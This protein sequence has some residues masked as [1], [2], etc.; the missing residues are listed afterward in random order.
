M[1]G[2]GK[3]LILNQCSDREIPRRPGDRLVTAVAA[4]T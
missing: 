2:E 3:V 4:V 1:I